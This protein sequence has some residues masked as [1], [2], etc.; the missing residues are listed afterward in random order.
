MNYLSIFGHKGK[1]MGY[2]SFIHILLEQGVNPVQAR[3]VY[4]ERLEIGL[5]RKGLRGFFR[6]ARNH[7]NR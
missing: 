6:L 4:L 5:I 3:R 7:E 1:C 2:D